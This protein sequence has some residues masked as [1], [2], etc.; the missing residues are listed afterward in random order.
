MDYIYIYV[1]LSLVGCDNSQ[2]S[3]PLVINW[4]LTK[5]NWELSQS[6]RG[7]PSTIITKE[8][9]TVAG[10]EHGSSNFHT[11]AVQVYWDPTLWGSIPLYIFIGFISSLQWW[12]STIINGHRTPTTKVI[13][14]YNTMK[15]I[16]SPKLWVHFLISLHWFTGKLEPEPP[17]FTGK[18]H[19]FRLRFSLKNQSNDPWNFL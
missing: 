6:T 16:V 3:V 5:I 17:R 14:H 4:Y 2:L 7:I 1:Y 12:P 18:N 19:G 13:H 10:F 11:T 9:R 15:I 8:R